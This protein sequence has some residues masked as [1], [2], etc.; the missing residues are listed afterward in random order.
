[1]VVE[2]KDGEHED[3]TTEEEQ[4][5]AVEDQSHALSRIRVLQQVTENKCTPMSSGD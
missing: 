5:Q 2:V 4:E 3:G 1:M